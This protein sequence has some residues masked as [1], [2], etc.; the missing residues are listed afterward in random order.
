MPVNVAVANDHK[1]FLAYIHGAVPLDQ[2]YGT[3]D[4]IA[5]L[6]TGTGTYRGLVIFERDV[7][8]REWDGVAV[9]D[10]IRG[11]ASV[12]RRLGLQRGE[13]AAVVHFAPEAQD[14]VR[15]WN[16]LSAFNWDVN[17]AFNIF[18]DV[19]PALRFLDVPSTVV[20]RVYALA[21]PSR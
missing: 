2:V 14:V 21:A 17:M 9:R 10:M 4:R 5:A 15:L 3:A 1:L 7:A 6:A 18:W 16:A 11:A 12:Y 19:S 13:S 20:E 8:L